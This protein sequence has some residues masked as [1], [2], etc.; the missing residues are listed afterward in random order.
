MGF[1][2]DFVAAL[3]SPVSCGVTEVA[4]FEEV[5][6]NVAGASV[7]SVLE[8][9]IFAVRQRVAHVLLAGQQRPAVV[10]RFTI[11]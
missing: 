7:L 8:V 10:N 11:P 9:V 3:V 2:A 6:M 5:N 1:D 4:C